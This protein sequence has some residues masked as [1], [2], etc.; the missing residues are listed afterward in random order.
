MIEAVNVVEKRTSD[1]IES[2]NKKDNLC[3]LPAFID[4]IELIAPVRKKIKKAVAAP[5][6]RNINQSLS[7]F[8]GTEICWILLTKLVGSYRSS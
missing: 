1:E 6:P 4:P 2:G 7:K 8:V 5:T 3:S